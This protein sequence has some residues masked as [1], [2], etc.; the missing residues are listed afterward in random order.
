MY[1]IKLCSL[2]SFSHDLP[3]RMLSHS[4]PHSIRR[5]DEAFASRSTEVLLAIMLDKRKLEDE[6]MF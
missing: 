5:G 1:A 2:V 6:R 3:C 4:R